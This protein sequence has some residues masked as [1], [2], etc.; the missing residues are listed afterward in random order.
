MT[1]FAQSVNVLISPSEYLAEQAIRHK[2]PKPRVI[3]HGFSKQ[4]ANHKG[5]F[6]FVF[7]GGTQWHKGLDILGEAYQRAKSSNKNFPKIR[8]MVMIQILCQILTTL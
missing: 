1:E 5:G 2:L 6:G 4:N 8:F 3:R 7:L